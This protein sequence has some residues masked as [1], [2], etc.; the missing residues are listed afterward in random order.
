[1]TSPSTY[2][3]VIL[4]MTLI[5]SAVITGILALVGSVIGFLVAGVTGLVSALVGV[6]LADSSS[7]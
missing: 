7:G 6:V 5:W 1:M 3:S 4:R 2:G